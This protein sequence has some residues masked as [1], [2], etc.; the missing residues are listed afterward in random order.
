[1]LIRINVFLTWSATCLKT[2]IS[3]HAGFLVQLIRTQ[4]SNP[5]YPSP[6]AKQILICQITSQGQTHWAEP[7]RWR[8]CSGHLH[9]I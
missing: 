2:C 9:Y 7:I 4:P 8:N 3:F 6:P 1:M 5:L